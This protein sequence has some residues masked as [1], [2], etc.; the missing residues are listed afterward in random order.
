MGVDSSVK[1]LIVVDLPGELEGHGN[2]LQAVVEMVLHGGDCNVVVDFSN[3]DIVGSLTFSRL[4]EL[5][6]LLRGSGQKLVLCGVSPT[7]RAV[8]SVTLLDKLFDFVEDKPIALAS[9][10]GCT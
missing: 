3:T 2:E 8:F 4:L 1:N 5:R 7:A 6:R 10:Q 9:L